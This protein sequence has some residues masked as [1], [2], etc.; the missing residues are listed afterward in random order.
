MP[1]KLDKSNLISNLNNKL[2]SSFMRINVIQGQNHIPYFPGTQLNLKR[3]LL[4]AREIIT[5][6]L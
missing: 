3:S 4:A 2:S 5:L 1:L 6:K